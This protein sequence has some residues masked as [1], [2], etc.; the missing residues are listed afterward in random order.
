MRRLLQ[1]AVSLVLVISIV[2]FQKPIT[3]YVAWFGAGFSLFKASASPQPDD[4]QI[5]K[6]NFTSD[7]PAVCWDK[8]GNA[9]VLFWSDA[10]GNRE[11]YYVHWNGYTWVNAAGAVWD[12]TTF[13]ANVSQN[14]ATS[15]YGM[16][17]L[18]SLGRP[19][20]LWKDMTQ[21]DHGL[22]YV[23]WNGANWVTANGTL[24]NGSNAN[25]GFVGGP[26]S[27]RFKD[28]YL[29]IDSLNIP[30]VVFADSYS[31]N[32]EVYYIHWGGSN[33][34]TVN[35]AVFDNVTGANAN[36][37]QNSTDSRDPSIAIDSFLLPRIS[38]VDRLPSNNNMWTLN[39][40]KWNGTAW[41]ALDD[42]VYNPIFDNMCVAKSSNRI[43]SSRLCIDKNG[44]NHLLSVID[45]VFLTKGD[46]CY[47]KSDGKLWKAA[48]GT[49]CY[50]DNPNPANITSN[51]GYSYTYSPT[52]MAVDDKGNAHIVW[53]ENSYKSPTANDLDI[54]YIHWNGTAWVNDAGQTWNPGTGNAAIIKN[55]LESSCAD[56]ALD[57]AGSPMVAWEDNTYSPNNSTEIMFIEMEQYDKGYTLTKS[58][59][60]NTNS[61]YIDTG[62]T[63]K[64]GDTLNYKLDLDINPVN[65]DPYN[66]YIF[67][68]IPSGTKYKAGTAKPTLDLAYSMDNGVTWTAGE[69]PNDS[70]SGTKLRWGPLWRD[71]VG[72]ADNRYNPALLQSQ[73]PFDIN[74]TRGEVYGRAFMCP[75]MDTDSKGYPNIATWVPFGAANDQKIFFFRWDGTNWVSMDGQI[76]VPSSG[77]ANAACVNPGPSTSAYVSMTLDSRDYPHLVWYERFNPAPIMNGVYYVR[78]DPAKGWVC[79]DGTK[80]NSLLGNARVTNYA[81]SYG[82]YPPSRCKIAVDS[83]NNPHIVFER[84]AGG[85]ASVVCYTYWDGVAWENPNGQLFNSNVPNAD[86]FFSSPVFYATVPKIAIDRQDKAHIIWTDTRTS[87]IYYIH[88]GNNAWLCRDG[89]AF[90]PATPTALSVNFSRT[91]GAT[92]YGE[93]C[94]GTDNSIHIAWEDTI[95]AGNSDICYVKSDSGA[96]WNCADGTPYN[97]LTINANFTND[98][99]FSRFTF[100]GDK[101][102]LDYLNYPHV[103]WED[104]FS[105][106][107]PLGN[108]V[109]YA[110]WNGKKWVNVRGELHSQFLDNFN[111]SRSFVRESSCPSVSVDLRDKPYVAWEE[112]NNTAPESCQIYFLKR[113]SYTFQF[114]VKIDNPFNYNY[115]PITNQGWMC[116]SDSGDCID[117]FKSNLVYNPVYRPKPDIYVQNIPDDMTICPTD[118]VA[119]TVT[120]TNR[121]DLA[122]T[123]TVLKYLLTRELLYISSSPT[124]AL[125]NGSLISELGTLKPGDKVQFKIYMKF[126]QKIQVVGEINATTEAVVTYSESTDPVRKPAIIS[127]ENCQEKRPLLLD[128]VWTGIDT[129]TSTGQSGQEIT[130]KFKPEWY[131]PGTS[132]YDFVVDWGDGTKEK[133]F[134]KVG[135]SY[136]VSKHTYQSAGEY[137]FWIKVDDSLA[138][139]Y[140]VT[141]ALHIK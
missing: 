50:P 25:I 46:L 23:K 75:S 136:L 93:L 83:K 47:F 11:I 60:V 114:S 26:G 106:L 37:S 109:C 18:D 112:G 138:R 72:M 124:M 140:K 87:E 111:V 125:G 134:D 86:L 44:A 76:Y 117:A 21:N 27:L 33:W 119:C 24:Y 36:I 35:G 30:H 139:S 85:G 31:G 131:D 3:G 120:V 77:S 6:D 88:Q 20:L 122:S 28:Y 40:V 9:H 94:I 132:P 73:Q 113:P 137:S 42:S 8:V 55:S 126:D 100:V 74:V 65:F 32:T 135:D 64:V 102:A 43:A 12:R 141:R 123:N 54:Y 133:F 96:W 89:S 15:N 1:Y 71:W 95:S 78:W 14:A 59:A 115:T 29:A 22:Y 49:V 81:C 101:M 99:G 16:M 90:N 4:I 68:V 7:C 45:F 53:E 84:D 69:P 129:K 97:N 80:Y 39:F 67:D 34:V 107:P 13:N 62:K 61:T 128:T 5:T 66:P 19:H 104:S 79:A 110:R 58:V 105:S 130:V 51:N 10:T 70:P 82:V 92:G 103:V 98:A 91:A 2:G 41:V 56:I 63:V 57:D 48:D 52:P 127:I 108:E 121:G 17:K 116:D 38:W 118:P